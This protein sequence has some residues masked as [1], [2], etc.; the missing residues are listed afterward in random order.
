MS[1]DERN[2][3]ADA[4]YIPAGPGCVHGWLCARCSKPSQML[5]RR[6]RFVRGART[7]VCAQCVQ[8]LPR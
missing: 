4:R 2:R 5:G 8:E 1:S 6:M 7:Y 3:P